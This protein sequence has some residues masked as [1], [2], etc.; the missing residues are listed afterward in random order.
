MKLYIKINDISYIEKLDI[1]LKRRWTFFK[2]I[3]NNFDI[4]PEFK[5]NILSLNELYENKEIFYETQKQTLSKLIKG[6]YFGNDYCE[7]LITDESEIKK[8]FSFAVENKLNF[9]LTL[10]VLSENKIKTLEKVLKETKH[11]LKEVV[12]ND[13]GSL[14]TVLEFGLKP[15]LGIFLTKKIKA[16]FIE[17]V[18]P[19]SLKKQEELMSHI[20]AEILEYRE[21]FKN[22][23]ISRISIEN[24]PIDTSF[25]KEKPYFYID[26]YYPYK[27]ISYSRACNIAGIFNDIQ[28]YFP[29][30]NCMKYCKDI[31]LESKDNLFDIFQRYNCNFK[32]QLK[33]NLDEN[34]IK[35]KKNRLIFEIFL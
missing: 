33:L 18:S 14:Y 20:E 16:A 23:G 31:G 3:E 4:Y 1:L 9:V 6:I 26:V 21:F 11:F 34:L 27:R 30:E 2:Q 17:K 29:V 25:L 12:V 35:N 15:V 19:Q 13:Y 28:K 5:A 32:T 10:P 24:E 22:L 8:A 7:H